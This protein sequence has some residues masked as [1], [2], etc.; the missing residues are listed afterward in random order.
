VLSLQQVQVLSLVGEPRSCI[1]QILLTVRSGQKNEK[2]TGFLKSECSVL[3]YFHISVKNL[4]S[5]SYLTIAQY[6][7][8]A[9]YLT[10]DM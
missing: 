9:S 7:I 4:A 8:S 2:K 5:S 10:L 6:A 1:S 3:F